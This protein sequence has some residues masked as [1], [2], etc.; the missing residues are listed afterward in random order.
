MKTKTKQLF[1]IDWRIAFVIMTGM[2][3]A[4]LFYTVTLSLQVRQGI[5]MTYK[6][7]MMEK[8]KAQK[9]S[10]KERKKGNIVRARREERG[11]RRRRRR[12]CR[13]CQ[14]WRE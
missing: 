1:K 9:K 8:T 7:M 10:K 2:F 3:V 13:R 12:R 6:K 5:K 11:E 4:L 14:S